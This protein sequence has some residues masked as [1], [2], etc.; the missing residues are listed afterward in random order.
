LTS[1]QDVILSAAQLRGAMQTKFRRVVAAKPEASRS[2]SP[3][4]YLLGL[5]F[6]EGDPSAGRGL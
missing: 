2:E 4:H 3:E 6:R 5:G 1:G